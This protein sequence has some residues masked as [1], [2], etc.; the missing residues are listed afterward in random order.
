MEFS[1]YSAKFSKE[2]LESRKKVPSELLP[3]L[4]EIQNQLLEDPDMHRDRVIPAGR[5]GNNFVYLHPDPAVQV[6]Y[7]V[8][9]RKKIIYF[10]HF[11]APSFDVKKNLFISYSH[12]DKKWLNEIR[13]FL[14]V[15][16]ENGEIKLWDDT[17]LEPG[18]PWHKQILDALESAQAGVLL[19]SQEFL[20]SDFISKT[21]LPKLLSGV[22]EKGKS[23]FWIHVSPSTVFDTHKEIT[24]FQSLQ[25]NPKKTLEE[26]Q[27]AERRKVLV[28]MSKKLSEA[29][30]TH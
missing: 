8:D 2:A 19:V 13:E 4:D 21:E 25:G 29:V 15:L 12:A 14:T 1:E 30:V 24:K 3:T 27:K 23:I 28:Q 10:F 11:A 16:E 18:K 9:K 26:M 17:Q 5:T 22:K 7:E 6:T 20:N